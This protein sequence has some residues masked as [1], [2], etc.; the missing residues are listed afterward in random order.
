MNLI[1]IQCTVNV[2]KSYCI[3]SNDKT[4]P[5]QITEVV[6]RPP[7]NLYSTVSPGLHWMTV[8]WFGTL[9]CSTLLC[10]VCHFRTIRPTIDDWWQKSAPTTLSKWHL[11]KQNWLQFMKCSNRQHECDHFLILFWTLHKTQTLTSKHCLTNSNVNDDN[12]FFF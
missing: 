4:Q 10:H 8:W 2:S 11:A 12:L 6:P 1:Y 3:F 5:R 7:D 9:G